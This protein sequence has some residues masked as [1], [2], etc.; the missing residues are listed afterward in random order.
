MN[1]FI[2]KIN[3][4]ILTKGK[5]LDVKAFSENANMNNWNLFL[6]D[7]SSQ[8]PRMNIFYLFFI[9]RLFNLFI[10]IQRFSPYG[11]SY[12]SLVCLHKATRWNTKKMSIDVM[13]QISL[14]FVI[15]TKSSATSSAFWIPIFVYKANCAWV[16]LWTTPFSACPTN[17]SIWK[18][19]RIISIARRF[20]CKNKTR[21][22]NMTD[23][24][25]ARTQGKTSNSQY[26]MFFH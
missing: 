17:K 15:K 7:K 4:P 25:M 14:S 9:N 11:I 12:F 3:F 18:V 19:S 26:W 23:I 22:D 5:K 1:I 16:R 2:E 20:F 10:S 21:E 13:L 6:I 8:I 24:K